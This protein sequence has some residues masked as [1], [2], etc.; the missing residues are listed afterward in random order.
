MSDD[1]LTIDT[2]EL[3]NKMRK[4]LSGV[5]AGT[6]RRAVR[7]ALKE[8]KIQAQEVTPTVPIVAGI[9]RGDSRSQ[10]SPEVK[11]NTLVTVVDGFLV[12]RAPYAAYQH[13]GMRRDGS[14]VV[15]NHSEPGSGAKFLEAKIA[16][17]DLRKRLLDVMG[18]I[19]N[20]GIKAGGDTG[21]SENA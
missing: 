2:R 12:Y 11:V 14:H 17:A 20:K 9:L 10:W 5:S 8:L 1:C 7:E 6:S 13:E 3:E 18:M 15:R 4:V 21:D 19:I 16:R